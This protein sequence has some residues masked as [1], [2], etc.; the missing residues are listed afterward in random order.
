MNFPMTLKAFAV[1]AAGSFAFA[2]SAFADDYDHHHRHDAGEA[3]V[4]IIGEVISGAV[5]AEAGQA[6]RARA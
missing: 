2:G 3:A 5:E 1:I 4:G 6:S